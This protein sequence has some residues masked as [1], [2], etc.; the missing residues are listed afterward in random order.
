MMFPTV[1]LSKSYIWQRER[2]VGS[3]LCFS[4]VARIKITCEGGSSNVF[5]KALKAAVESM[6]TSSMI[7]TLYLPTCGGT[8]VCSISVLMCSTELLLAASSSKMLYERCSAKALQLSHSPHASPSWVGCSQLMAL[9]K[10][11]AQVVFP[12]PL[13]P[14]NR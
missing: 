7:N 6:C 14:Q 12:T 1:I 3:I 10:I 2:M 5:R 8:R 4:V 11:R 13:G 9:A